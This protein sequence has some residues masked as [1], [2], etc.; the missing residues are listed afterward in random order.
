MTATAYRAALAKL[1]LTHIDAA[2]LFRVHRR[3]SHRW[4]SGE[5][6]VPYAV[7]ITLLLMIRYKVKPAKLA[8]LQKKWAA[9]SGD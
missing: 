3:T 8:A 5:R 6:P 2:K 9:L 4:A 7:E 1:G